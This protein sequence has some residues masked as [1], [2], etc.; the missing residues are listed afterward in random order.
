MKIRNR[1]ELLLDL[2]NRVGVG[3]HLIH[4]QNWEAEPADIQWAKELGLLVDAPLTDEVICPGCFEACPMPVKPTPSNPPRYF[5]MCDK[6]MGIGRVKIRNDILVRW[7]IHISGLAHCIC[8]HLQ[9]DA[10]KEVSGR[11]RLGLVKG[12]KDRSWLWLDLGQPVSLAINNNCKP[13]TNLMFIESNELAVDKNAI[14][15]MV[16]A[17]ESSIGAY[18]PNTSRREKGKQETQAKYDALRL[19]AREY[20]RKPQG[21]SETWVANQLKKT[22]LGKDYSVDH[23]RKI[24]RQ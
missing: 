17:P 16:D 7:Q 21:T 6:D 4:A 12:R 13:L 20:R 22:A 15:R 2:L 11:W 18:I 1:Q 19:A 5:V 24:I 23:I 10:P 14:K 3:A 9:L 8:K